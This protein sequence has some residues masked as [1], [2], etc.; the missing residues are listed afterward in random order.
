MGRLTNLKPSLGNAE[1]RLKR[2]TDEHGHSAVTEPWRK[3]Y[4]LKRWRGTKAGGWLD[5]LRGH[6]LVRDRFTC[7]WDGCGKLITNASE[8]V[9]HHVEAHKGDPVK[10]W[11]DGN[12][13]CVC[14]DCHDG[15][16][17]AMEAKASASGAYL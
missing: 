10:F 16:I 13:I 3:W 11:D 9:A 17:A 6:V 7:R 5:G 12:L 1:P 4:G 15:P 8:A 14:K 2:M